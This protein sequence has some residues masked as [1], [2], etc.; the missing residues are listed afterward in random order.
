MSFI[1]EGG[2]GGGLGFAINTRGDGGMGTWVGTAMGMMDHYSRLR[3]QK[4]EELGLATETAPQPLRPPPQDAVPWHHR[5]GLIGGGLNIILVKEHAA[6][7]VAM[8]RVFMSGE[9]PPSL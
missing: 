5:S 6:M 7:M 1:E 2:G 9:A 8:P 3:R 4:E